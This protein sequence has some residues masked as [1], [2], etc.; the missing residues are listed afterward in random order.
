MKKVNRLEDA[1]NYF[2]SDDVNRGVIVRDNGDFRVR[3]AVVN[4][5]SEANNTVNVTFYGFTRDV[6]LAGA[7][8][9][10]GGSEIKLSDFR[11]GDKLAAHGNFNELTK[12][13][14]IKEV[15]NISYNRGVR[16]GDIEK[17]INEL[18]KM[19]EELKA[20]LNGLR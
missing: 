7:K 20:K 16:T 1:F 8:L 12:S 13:L 5:I 6:S 4:S 19:I 2:L 15:H 17:R 9:I 18:L 14:T 3:G 10:G 11:T